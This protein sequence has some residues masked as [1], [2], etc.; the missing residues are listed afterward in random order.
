MPI[1]RDLSHLPAGDP[2]AANAAVPPDSDPWL[3]RALAE[4]WL[5]E[6]GD[7]SRP[8][9]M[10]DRRFRASW[11]GTRCDRALS[12]SLAGVE[13]TNASTVADLWR[14]ALGTMIHDALQGSMHRAFPDATCEVSIDLRPDLDGCGTVDILVQHADRRTAVEVKSINGFGFKMAA[15]S[16]KGGEEGPKW[17][18]VVQGA[19]GAY[20]LDADELVLAYFSMELVSAAGLRAEHGEIGRFT[21]QWTYPRDIYEPIARAEIARVNRLLVLADDLGGA[22]P[23]RIVHD[24][25]IPPSAV[26]VDP[27]RSRWVVRDDKGVQQVGTTWHCTYC[28]HRDRCISDGA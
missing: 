22:L 2:K 18:H 21:A 27:A 4:A 28:R 3:V 5:T 1:N 13:E 9:S 25:S 26:V 10:P 8:M 17:G 16:F 24:P 23:P 6:Q 14:M 20:A 15:T 12:Y 7:T 11:A 19:L